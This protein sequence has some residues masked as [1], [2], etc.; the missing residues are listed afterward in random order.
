MP[1]K[2]KWDDYCGSSERWIPL[3]CVGEKAF[4][5]SWGFGSLQGCVCG[6]EWN[7]A[8]V[9]GHCCCWRSSLCVQVT[10]WW[11]SYSL[12]RTLLRPH[13]MT[14]IPVSCPHNPP[15][16][17]SPDERQVAAYTSSCL[18]RVAPERFPFTLPMPSQPITVSWG[19]IGCDPQPL[20]SCAAAAVW[21]CVTS[22]YYFHGRDTQDK[23]GKEEGTVGVE[24]ETA[25]QLVRGCMCVQET[26]VFPTFLLCS[27][28]CGRVEGP[29]CSTM[30]PAGGAVNCKWLP[31]GLRRSFLGL[32]IYPLS[33]CLA[34]IGSVLGR[35]FLLISLPPTSCLWLPKLFDTKNNSALKVKAPC[36]SKKKKNVCF[37]YEF[38]RYMVNCGF[39]IVFLESS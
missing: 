5:E 12:G 38:L 23:E 14:C 1:L 20:T 17:I 36:V 32:V 35:Y 19:N 39:K 26:S 4:S 13:V 30:Q 22:A 9:L 29:G 15:S 6:R 11:G 37:V 8:T 10:S 2:K 18:S 7:C 16:G 34:L 28:A 3:Y 24:G 31:M 33:S 25:W 21:L 27:C